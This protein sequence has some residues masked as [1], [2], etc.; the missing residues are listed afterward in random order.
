MQRADRCRTDY[1]LYR[2]TLTSF[3]KKQPACLR[4]LFTSERQTAAYLRYNPSRPNHRQ[5][6]PLQFPPHRH[7]RK[8]DFRT[9]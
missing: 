1:R 7:D 9:V 2:S 8:T 3:R 6:L 4:L 5:R